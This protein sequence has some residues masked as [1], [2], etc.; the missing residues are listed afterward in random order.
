MSDYLLK[1]IRLS[2]DN[3][4]YYVWH[5]I[6]SR[7]KLYPIT[8]QKLLKSLDL[9]VYIGKGPDGM[10]LVSWIK[11]QPL[12]WDVTVVDTL[13]DRIPVL[14]TERATRGKKRAK[15]VKWKRR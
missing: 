9:V 3:L 11:G 14:P 15:R 1:K 13:A 6:Y 4:N 2:S 7:K 8:P 12:V 5:C 10:T